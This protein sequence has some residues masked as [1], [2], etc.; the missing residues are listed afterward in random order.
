[1]IQA[2]AEM[3]CQICGW[4][5]RY[6]ID[7]I[8][9]PMINPDPCADRRDPGNYRLICAKHTCLP[10]DHWEKSRKRAGLPAEIDPVLA[11]LAAEYT[12]HTSRLKGVLFNIQLSQPPSPAWDAEP[13]PQP[14]PE[15]EPEPEVEEIPVLDTAFEIDFT[16]ELEPEPEFESDLDLDPLPPS[17]YALVRELGLNRTLTRMLLH[18]ARDGNWHFGSRMAHKLRK[19]FSPRMVRYALDKLTGAE[20]LVRAVDSSSAVCYRRVD[21]QVLPQRPPLSVAA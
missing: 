20:V 18:E 16:P 7:R 14:E 5:Q 1:M 2:Q 6:G 10:P 3:R 9:Y 4:A 17:V 8:E 13:E 21:M 11:D 15:P 19:R 12:V